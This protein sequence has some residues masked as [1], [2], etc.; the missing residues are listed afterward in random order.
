MHAQSW[1]HWH[2]DQREKLA[3]SAQVT[4]KEKT[5][6]RNEKE[7]ADANSKTDDNYKDPRRRRLE[8]WRRAKREKGPTTTTTTTDDDDN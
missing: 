6:Q 3:R 8:K 4:R 5:K 7:R 2:Q 1:Q